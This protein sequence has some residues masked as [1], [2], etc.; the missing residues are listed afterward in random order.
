MDGIQSNGEKQWIAPRLLY[1]LTGVASAIPV[2]W[3]FGW[4]VY[5]AGISIIEYISLLGSLILLASAAVPKRRLAARVAL[6]GAM[7]AW[8]FYLP[9]IVVAASVWL[10]DQEIRLSV[11]LWTPSAS[12]LVIEEPRQP[13]PEMRLS[14]QEVQQIKD[15]GITGMLFTFGGFTA[16]SYR[17][18]KKSRVILIMQRPV[19]EAIEL[20]EPDATSIVYI[21][22]G[23]RWRM[24]PPHAATLQR[25]IR[26]EP[27]A[28]DPNQTSV[29]A[30]LSTGARQ[31]FGVWWRK[32]QLEK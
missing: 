3:A 8:S 17:R 12:P 24:F 5:G 32:A 7:A 25:T 16:N 31:G 14:P 26:I 20:N 27:E 9:A 18:D 13:P 1:L 21:Q 23:T 10:T 15:T 30:E 6:V 19:N 11:L 4:A 22:D 2:V 28:D 29:L